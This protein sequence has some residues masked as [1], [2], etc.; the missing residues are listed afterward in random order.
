M[1]KVKMQGTIGILDTAV[2]DKIL[3]P[4]AVHDVDGVPVPHLFHLPGRCKNYRVFRSA[5]GDQASLDHQAVFTDAV[6]VSIFF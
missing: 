3:S 6:P 2:L 1:G 5:L 4:G